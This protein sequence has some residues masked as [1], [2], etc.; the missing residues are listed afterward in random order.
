MP[1]LRVACEVLNSDYNREAMDI[2]KSLHPAERLVRLREQLGL[3]QRELAKEFQVS[4][5]AIACWETGARA[6]PGPILKLMEL[7]EDSLPSMGKQRTS[8]ETQKLLE[9]IRDS[10]SSATQDRDSQTVRSLSEGMEEYLE[11]AISMNSLSGKIKHLFIQRLVN[12]LHSRKGVSVKVAQLASFLEMGLPME[13]RQALGTL[14]S[15]AIPEKPKVIQKILEE[16]YGKPMKEVFSYWREE[17]LAVTSL[18][19]V[20]YARLLD[21][22]EVAVKVQH[23]NIRGTLN[24]QIQKLELVQSLVAFLGKDAANIT[25]EISRSLLQECDYQQEA[26]NQEKFRNLLS[27]FPGV[28]V[29]RV[30]RDLIRERVLVSQFIKAESFQS[31]VTR[32]TQEQRNVA[33]ESLLGALS[34]AA[35]GYCLTYSDLHPGNFLFTDGKV[36][37]LDFGRVIDYPRERMKVES[38]FYQHFLERDYERC[39]QMAPALFAKEGAEFDFDAFW[40]FLMKANVHLLTEGKFRFTRDYAKAISREGRVFNKKYQLQMNKDVFWAFVYSASTWAILADLD[41]E[42]PMR[43]IAQKTIRLGLDL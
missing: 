27:D 3:S 15:R 33:A 30:H 41:A 37:L 22:D 28:I 13:I 23:P 10:L 36:V 8:S 38:R 19:Q 39:S 42:V 35:F 40:N 12:S 2:M 43:R 16:E 6:I 14:Q 24:K 1:V 25:P 18:G 11:D 34:T 20:H 4:S 9:R 32:A 5:G 31:F 7:Y 29:P 26:L 21:G 17:P